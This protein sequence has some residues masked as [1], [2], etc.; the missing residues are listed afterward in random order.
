MISRPLITGS[1][2]GLSRAAVFF[3]RGFCS[4]ALFESNVIRISGID[5]DRFIR[6]VSDASRDIRYMTDTKPQNTPTDSD[7]PCEKRQNNAPERKIV[8]V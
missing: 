3:A 2:L 8:Q 1:V 7:S 6:N 5:V 4:M